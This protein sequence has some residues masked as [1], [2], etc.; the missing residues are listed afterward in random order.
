[1]ATIVEFGRLSSK[2]Q[3]AIPARIRA[4]MKLKQGARLVFRLEK[5]TLVISEIVPGTWEKITAPWKK[6]AKEAGLREEDVMDIIARVRARRRA[7]Q[8]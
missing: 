7:E 8:T 1:M 2:G 4:Q 3:V 6:A 5:D